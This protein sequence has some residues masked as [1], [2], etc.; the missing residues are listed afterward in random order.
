MMQEQRASFEGAEAPDEMLEV[1]DAAGQPIGRAPRSECHGNPELA[2]RAVHVLVHDRHGR[3]YLQKRS[4]RKRIQPGKWDSSVGGHVDP[5]ESYEQA[6][7]RE[8]AEELGVRLDTIGGLGALRHRHDY[9]WRSPVET[10]HIRTFQLEHDGPFRLQQEEIDEGRFWTEQQ[11]RAA[12]GNGEL[13]PN[14][15]EELR[16]FGVID[17]S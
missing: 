1:V 15:E 16:R 3:F 2:H 13:T 17:E 4:T 10:E 6:A 14:L 11:L 5:G 12:A 7:Q 9:I 8:L